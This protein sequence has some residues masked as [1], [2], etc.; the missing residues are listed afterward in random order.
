MATIFDID[1]WKEIWETISRNR[2]RSVLTG[3]GVFWGIFMFTVMMGFGTWLNRFTL[4]TLGDISTNTTFMF[5]SQTSIPYRGMPS[6]RWWTL[7]TN[8]IESIRKQIPEVRHIAAMH[9][10]GPQQTT[11]NDRK[12]TYYLLGCYPEYIDIYPQPLRFGR[13]INRPDIDNRRK[14]CVIGE[15]IWRELFPDG[16]NPVGKAINM[17]GLYLDIVGVIQRGSTVIHIGSDTETTIFT[18]ITM[19]QQ[20]WNV[21]NAVDMIMVTA[22]DKTDIMDIDRRCRSII[23]ANHI[24]SPDDP[25]AISGFNLGEVFGRVQNM[26]GGL[27]LLTWVVGLETLLAGIVGVSNIM[28]VVVRERTQEIGIRRAIGARPSSI[29]SQ[30]LSESFILTFI[31]GI[32]GLATGVGA[33]TVL[34]KVVASAFDEPIPPLQISFWL[35]ITATLI[36]IA[37]SL[38][39]GIIPAGRALRIKAV[40]AIREE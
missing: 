31:S 28:L 22:D 12:G 14:V 23:A 21:G 8:D 4:A 17:N 33:L 20:L 16:S 26:F 2:K 30:I 1:C 19:T 15:Q 24:I 37:G 11:Y 38:L 29:I 7:D 35:G 34:E 18:P 9:M 13:F 25:K 27:S 32:F 39:A 5:P 3:L 40:D 6:G 36:I 10:A